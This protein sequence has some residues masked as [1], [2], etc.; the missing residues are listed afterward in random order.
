MIPRF[1]RFLGSK[2]R[3][4]QPSLGLLVN[5]QVIDVAQLLTHEVQEAGLQEG[6]IEEIIHGSW[7]SPVTRGFID[8]IL[9]DCSRNNLPETS[10]LSPEQD[11]FKVLSPLTPPRN[12][13]C[14]GKNYSDHI[15][16]VAAVRK[17]E[18]TEAPK[19]PVIFTKAPQCVVADGD[20]VPAHTSLTSWLDYEVEL[21]V[22]IGKGGCD[23]S[24]ETAMD[25][26]FGFSVANDITARELQKSHKQWFKGKSLDGTCPIGPCIVPATHLDH[27]DLALK[28]RVNGELRQDS[29]TSRMIFDVPSIIASLS[30]GMTLLPGDCILT[31]T[32]DGV[33]FAMKPPQVLKAGDTVECEIENIGTLTNTIVA[34]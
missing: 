27:T 20:N 34:K 7:N 8:E 3:P 9:D 4:T 11:N 26:V 12:V 31:G 30:A 25:H 13:M 24:K 10:L 19:Y 23:I 16:E 14:I 32:P 28:C 5:E 29:R 6:I 2:Y 1:T 17:G 18:P 22:V 15:A 33:G 21:C